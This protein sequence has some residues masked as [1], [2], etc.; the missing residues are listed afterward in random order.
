[1]TPVKHLENYC[2][3]TIITTSTEEQPILLFPDILV[4]L[5]SSF[6]LEARGNPQ[7]LGVLEEKRL[8]AGEYNFPDLKAIEG[9]EEREVLLDSATVLFLEK[10]LCF[11]ESLGGAQQRSLL[12]FP[13]LINEKRPKTSGI[14]TEDDVSYL[15]S[16]S[17]ENV[18]ASLVVLLGY[19]DH[20]T[21]KNQWQN[22][23]QYELKAD[24]ICGFRQLSEHE[25][26]IELTLYYNQNTPQ[27]G[28]M[29]FQGLFETFLLH[30]D[31]EVTRYEV[32]LCP[33]PECQEQQER[34]AVMKRIE[35]G[36]SEIFCSNCGMKIPIPETKALNPAA[37]LDRDTLARE[38]ASVARRTQFEAALVRIKAILREMREEAPEPICFISYAWGVPEHEKWVLQL[39]K[40]LRNAEI[41]VL[42]D[43]WHNEPGDSITRF[44]SNIAVVDFA[45]AVGT[46]KYRE[47]FEIETAD[48]VVDME[49]R[50]IETRLRKRSAIRKTVI[51]LLLEGA[52]GEAFPPL[53]EDSVYINFKD[54]KRYFVELFRLILRL[55]GIPFDHPGL[56]E[57][58]ASMEPRNFN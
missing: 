35:K 7:G 20:F 57:L 50:L 31:V 47:K 27:P 36:K 48:P 14:I 42:L 15:V 40:D 8:L 22:Q 30:R 3:V 11:R 56:D 41:K 53:F 2:Y 23:A 19:T 51:P 38:E 34:A 21:R 49:I 32:V 43:R 26:E 6:V 12:V 28:R 37:H 33:N 17:V 13:S 29:L 58:I 16:G 25:G 18:Y 1:M 39:A 9:E 5:A 52:Q 44:I 24:Q 45:L 46:K 54:E 55:Y 4:N 10:N